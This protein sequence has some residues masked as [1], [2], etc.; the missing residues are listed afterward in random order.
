MNLYLGLSALLVANE[1]KVKG[2]RTP[3]GGKEAEAEGRG[4]LALIE[5][6]GGKYSGTMLDGMGI[7]TAFADVTGREYSS[8]TLEGIGML[9]GMTEVTGGIPRT[10]TLEKTTSSTKPLIEGCIISVMVTLTVV[11]QVVVVTP[12]LG[13]YAAELRANGITVIISTITTSLETAGGGGGG[14]IGACPSS[15][16]KSLSSIILSSSISCFIVSAEAVISPD[17]TCLFTRLAW[18]LLHTYLP[19]FVRSGTWRKVSGFR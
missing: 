14:G 17:G 7:A 11:V 12:L 5:V 15:K 16:D 3:I 4:I 9:S 1:F 8:T 2:G 6:A 10:T 18:L 13:K 19:I